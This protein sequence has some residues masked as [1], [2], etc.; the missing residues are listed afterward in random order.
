TDPLAVLQRVE[1]NPR[2]PAGTVAYQGSLHVAR[3][4]PVI[5]GFQ[6]EREARLLVGGGDPVR[7][8]TQQITRDLV[9]KGLVKDRIVLPAGAVAIRFAAPPDARLV[10]S[11]V[12]RRGDPE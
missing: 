4:G 8:D 9:G 12:G 5:I 7:G 10:W 2:D 1:S 3:G 6:T 11:P